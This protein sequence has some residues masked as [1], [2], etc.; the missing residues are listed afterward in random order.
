MSKQ[1]TLPIS[2]A[3]VVLRDPKSLKQKDRKKVYVDGELSVSTGVQMIENII[4]VLI[5]SWS[6]DLFIPAVDIAT[7]GELDLADYDV[8]EAEA[9]AAMPALFPSLAK[10]TDNEADPLA[11]T[12]DSTD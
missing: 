12:G 1:I 5:E 8:L 10:T 3:T 6:L 9:K 11:I 2:K 7:L 4:S